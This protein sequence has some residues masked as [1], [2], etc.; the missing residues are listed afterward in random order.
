MKMGQKLTYRD[1]KIEQDSSSPSAS[2]LEN[3]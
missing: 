3:S 2:V 1:S